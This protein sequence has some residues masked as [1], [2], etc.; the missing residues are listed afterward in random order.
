MA[1]DPLGSA[2]GENELTLLEGALG[3]IS[4]NVTVF[5]II[6]SFQHDIYCYNLK[7]FHN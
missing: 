4:V 6:C 3:V 7:F 2:L 1:E 5:A